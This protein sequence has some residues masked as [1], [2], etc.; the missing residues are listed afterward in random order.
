MSRFRSCALMALVALSASAARAQYPAMATTD[1]TGITVFGTGELQTMPNLVE[2]DLRAGGSS[3]LTA[4]SIVKYQDAKRRALEAFEE[5]KLEDLTIEEHGLNLSAGGNSTA[6]MQMM[7]NGM[8]VCTCNMIMGMCKC[9]MTEDGCCFT[10]TSGDKACCDMIQAMCASMMSMMK[11]GC[12][13]CMMM[14]N[15]PVCYAC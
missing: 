13:C 1:S 6:Q 9:E 2:I 14:N 12:T 8:V 3:E 5:L 7:M 11:G 10:C 4:D 15:M